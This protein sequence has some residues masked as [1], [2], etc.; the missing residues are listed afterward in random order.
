[1]LWLIPTAITVLSIGWALLVHKD[2]R[3]YGQGIGNLL[4]LVPALG[5]SLVAWIIYAIY[6][7]W[8]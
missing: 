1:M 5:V 6:I 8:R 4:L 2:T 3:G 7:N